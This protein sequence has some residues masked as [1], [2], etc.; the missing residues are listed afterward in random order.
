MT[1]NLEQRMQEI[2]GSR[3]G[4]LLWQLRHYAGTMQ[5]FD[6]TFY[7]REPILSV[8]L[9]HSWARDFCAALMFGGS[10]QR[11]RKVL[12]HVTFSDGTTVSLGEIWTLN[13]MPADLDTT[14]VDLA[15]GEDVIGQGGETVRQIVH[16]TY[17]CR[18][19]AEEDFFLA[20][21]I[22]S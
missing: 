3:E 5:M 16:E 7:D 8:T 22:A 12:D 9:S 20:R 2:F 21:W 1:T 11:I 4:H 10:S 15:R 19:R 6:A 17:R 18:S 13:Y 14:G